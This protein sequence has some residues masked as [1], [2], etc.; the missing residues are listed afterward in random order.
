MMVV[1]M[2]NPDHQ[3]LDYEIAS[4]NFNRETTLFQPKPDYWKNQVWEFAE[5]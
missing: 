5:I 3:I 1:G 2:N 4:I